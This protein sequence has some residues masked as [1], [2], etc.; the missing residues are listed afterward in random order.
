MT[1][2]PLSAIVLTAYELLVVVGLLGTASIAM[3]IGAAARVAHVSPMPLR[4]G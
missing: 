3:A 2:T 1:N 4:K